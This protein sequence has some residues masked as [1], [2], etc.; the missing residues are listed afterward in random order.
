[1]AIPSQAKT[2]GA[3]KIFL[4]VPT[5]NPAAGRTGA[6]VSIRSKS[7][8]STFLG[9]GRAKELIEVA[10]LVSPDEFAESLDVPCDGFADIPVPC[11]PL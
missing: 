4:A 5:K 10:V 9:A 1:M 2:A 7:S 11:L 6:G 3:R 8:G